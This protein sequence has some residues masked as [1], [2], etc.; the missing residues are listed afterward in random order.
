MS[1][2]T[3]CHDK[4][5]IIFKKKMQQVFG[6]NILQQPNRACTCHPSQTAQM[7]FQNAH[8][9]MSHNNKHED[10]SRA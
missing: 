9:P 4:M 6:D 3:N 8:D 7:K 10:I 2:G 1:H 5:Q